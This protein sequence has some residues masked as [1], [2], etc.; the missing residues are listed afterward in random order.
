M[1]FMANAFVLF[2]LCECVCVCV[3]HRFE[4]QRALQALSIITI[5]Q[6]L[7]R[8]IFPWV[9]YQVVHKENYI[10]TPIIWRGLWNHSGSPWQANVN[11]KT[12]RLIFSQ[13]VWGWPY[14]SFY[15]CFLSR[16]S[17]P[18]LYLLLDIL[19]TFP[20]TYTLSGKFMSYLF[21]SAF[22]SAWM[23]CLVL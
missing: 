21:W 8:K 15:C 9:F 20:E 22:S 16:Q 4:A 23:M 6:Y 5:K 2:L 3:L 1:V 18:G 7:L 11:I 14:W 17:L 12:T 10:G 19:V 13:S